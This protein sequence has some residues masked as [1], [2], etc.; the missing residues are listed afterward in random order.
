MDAHQHSLVG[1]PPARRQHSL[2][3]A[4]I[5]AVAGLV[6]PVV[7]TAGFLAQQWVRRDSYDWVAEPV[8]NLEAGPSGWVQQAN[9]ALFGTCMLLLAGALFRELGGPARR[10]VGPVFVG[11]SGLGLF[12]AAVFAIEADA[13]GVAYD[14][15]GHFLAGGI[16]FFL[17]SALALLTLGVTLR[18][19]QQWRGVARYAVV[20]GLLA[21][22]G[23]V[24][25]GAFAVPDE[26]PLHPWAG[27]LQRVVIVLVT[28]PCIVA[29]SARLRRIARVA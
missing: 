7:F 11:L 18:S 14:P 10:R 20:C 23:F 28:F 21:L 9:F 25:L 26:A 19:D 12:G 16:M 27:L 8:S 15:G 6:G 17:N 13:N 24:L 3:L 29:V 2:D 5:G 4:G 22:A 1:A